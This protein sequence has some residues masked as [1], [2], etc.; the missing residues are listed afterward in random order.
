M[1]GKAVIR[2][3]WCWGGWAGRTPAVGGGSGGDLSA[4][5]EPEQGSGTH[6][7]SQGQAPGVLGAFPPPWEGSRLDPADLSELM[8]M[9][10]VASAGS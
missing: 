9:K 4:P 8:L 5:P 2:Q 7:T 10:P 6:P 3:G 1:L